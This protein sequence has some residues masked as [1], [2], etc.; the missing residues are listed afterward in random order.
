MKYFFS[1]STI[2]ISTQPILAS[3][4]PTRLN[5]SCL[6]KSHN[7]EKTGSSNPEKPEI[8]AIFIFVP[9]MKRVVLW[10]SLESNATKIL[11]TLKFLT[12][13]SLW[14]IRPGLNANEIQIP[15]DKH[16]KVSSFVK[17]HLNI[18]NSVKYEVEWK[19][20]ITLPNMKY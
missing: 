10:S 17:S 6:L 16:H 3:S 20:Q 1:A 18:H 11:T 19:F 4:F 12:S 15:Y 8:Q 9:L 5:F 2:S 14:Q 13:G 7:P